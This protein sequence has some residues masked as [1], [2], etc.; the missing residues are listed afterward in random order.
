MLRMVQQNGAF[1]GTSAGCRQ[2]PTGIRWVN[3]GHEPNTLNVEASLTYQVARGL[4]PGAIGRLQAI[5]GLMK[6]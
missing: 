5:S 3:G 4:R 2:N 1:A 6:G